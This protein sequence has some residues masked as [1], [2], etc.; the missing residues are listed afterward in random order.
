M[1]DIASADGDIGDDEQAVLDKIAKRIG[2]YQ[3]V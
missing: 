1:L 2:G 3:Q